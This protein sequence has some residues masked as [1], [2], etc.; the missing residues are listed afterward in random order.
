MKK[1]IAS[2]LCLTIAMS[3]AA[4]SKKAPETTSAGNAETTVQTTATAPSAE[5]SATVTTV[6]NP[7]SEFVKERIEKLKC[8]SYDDDDEDGEY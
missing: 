6:Y 4:C 1:L 2:I 3:L 7:A 5:P 8:K